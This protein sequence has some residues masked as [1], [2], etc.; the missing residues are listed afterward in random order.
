MAVMFLIA[1]GVYAVAKW[2]QNSRD[3]YSKPANY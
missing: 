2:Q 1:G 3:P